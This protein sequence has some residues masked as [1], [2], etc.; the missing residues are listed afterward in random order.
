MKCAAFEL[1]F[2]GDERFGK[3]NLVEILELPRGARSCCTARAERWHWTSESYPADAVSLRSV[4][5]DNFVVQDVTREPRIIA[6]VDYDSAP[7]MV[8]EKAIYILEG[9]TYYVEK[10]DHKERRGHVREAEV[11]YYTDAITYTKVRI[12]ERFAEERARQRPAQPR[13]GARHVAGGGLQE[14]QVPHERER[15]RGR[16]HACPRTRCTRPRTGSRCRAS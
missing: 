14:D 3:E 1:P 6:E 5:S 12:L 9:R 2:A 11:D 8:H 10:Y 13:R 16:A 4:S 15:G 7:S